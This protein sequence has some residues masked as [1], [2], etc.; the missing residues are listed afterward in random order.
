VIATAAGLVAVLAQAI[1]RQVDDSAARRLHDGSTYFR[2]ALEDERAALLTVGQ[3]VSQEP[4]FIEAV[5]TQDTTTN[6]SFS[7]S[8]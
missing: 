2:S 8:Q 6:S 4:E 7:I 3:L 1:N 5:R